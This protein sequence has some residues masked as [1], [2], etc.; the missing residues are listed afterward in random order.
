[1]RLSIDN[2]LAEPV[3]A[4]VSPGGGYGVRGMHERADACGGRLFAGAADGRWRID[5]ELP[6]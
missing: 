1:V 6:A 5:V 4:A 2:D 3:A